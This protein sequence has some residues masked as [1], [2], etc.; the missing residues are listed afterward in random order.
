MALSECRIL[1]LGKERC[2]NE[3][4]LR[5]RVAILVLVIYYHCMKKS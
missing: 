4:I 3:S 5:E 2:L 1:S